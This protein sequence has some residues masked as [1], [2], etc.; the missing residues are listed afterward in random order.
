M[1]FIKN[2][3]KQAFVAGW[4]FLSLSLKANAQV[5]V[6]SSVDKSRIKIGDLI[7]YEVHFYY[8]KGIEIQTPGLGSNLGAFEIREFEDLPSQEN[9]GSFEKVVTYTI[10]TFDT[11]AYVIPPISVGYTVLADSSEHFIET[12]PID[13]YVESMRPSEEGDI[14]DLKAQAEIPLDIKR[15]ILYVL[16]GLAIILALVLFWWYRKKRQQGGLFGKPEPPPRPAHEIAL[17]RLNN[18]E[19]SG[20]LAA[21]EIKDYFTELSEILREYIEGRFFIPAL[22]ST[23]FEVMQ[24]FNKSEFHSVET[25]DV[26]KNL[27]LSDLVKFARFIPGEEEVQVAF[28]TTRSFIEKTMIVEKVED[29]L[30]AT[31]A[32]KQA[33]VEQTDASKP[34]EEE[35][36]S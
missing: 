29:E 26:E 8:D 27:T 30:Q 5:R 25:E 16:I 34:Q 17:E 24:D 22:E 12:E 35:V 6:N 20:M 21:G 10:S 36:S 31:K 7:Q 14:R 13:V 28:A 23:T 3:W 9:N 33:E 19:A 18:L 4:I 1:I 11:G 2:I 32:E 15:I